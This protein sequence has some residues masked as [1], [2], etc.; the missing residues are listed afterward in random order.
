[1]L[2]Y[3]SCGYTTVLEHN[4]DVDNTFQLYQVLMNSIHTC[5]DR[6][7]QV[8]NLSNDKDAHMFS[9]SKLH[10]ST[11]EVFVMAFHKNKC[12]MLA[13]KSQSHEHTQSLILLF[14]S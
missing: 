7:L 5:M 14:E 12:I 2:H 6:R 8:F 3:V 11:S 1:M 13:G 9:I 4:E 10:K